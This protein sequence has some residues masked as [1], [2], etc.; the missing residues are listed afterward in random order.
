MVRSW[1]RLL[2]RATEVLRTEGLRSFFFK[3][4]GETVYR[5]VVVVERDLSQ[6]PPVVQARLPVSIVRLCDSEIEEY[7]AFR[8][9]TDAAEVRRRLQAGQVCWLVRYEGRI[10][11]SCWVTT[12]RAWIEYLGWDVAL[13]PDTAYS[14]ESFTAPELRGQNLA[15]ARSVVMQQALRQAGYRRAVAVI[16]PENRAGFYPAEKAGYRRV[17]VMGYLRIGPWR[18]T[19]GRDAFYR[20]IRTDE[21][22]YWD[23]VA[24]RSRERPP[25]LDPFLGEL[26]RQAHLALIRRWGGLTDAGWVMKTDLYEEATGP[27]AFLPDLEGERRR[28]LGIDLS[29]VIVQEAQRR[30]SS[31]AA[32]YVVA[33]VRRLPLADR[34]IACIV[35]PST[36]DHFPDPADLGRSLSELRRVLAT[37]G[38]LIVTVDNRQN[39]LDPLLRLI[40]RLG[41]APYYLGRSYRI[42]ELVRALEAAGLTVRDTTAI[43]HNPRLMA[44]AAVAVA[45]RLRWPQFRNVVQRAL[46]AAQR[47]E[48]T[49]WQYL[50][51]SFIAAL[52][53]RSAS[54]EER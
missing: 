30:H 12:G 25:Y 46:I 27:D 23:Q 22:A 21:P 14:Y 2:R 34:T 47:L 52:A 6:P 38:R 18:W 15:V 35:S 29:P 31:T 44:T 33:D 50:T 1:S 10:V 4:L 5:R 42:G 36:L 39:I 37:S 48:G 17:G 19:F 8:P 41:R 24:R 54:A 45:D 20:P 11:H 32:H 43:L 51:G 26:K 40:A 49:R 3:V 7:V 28:L 16:M 13:P 53:I 9:E